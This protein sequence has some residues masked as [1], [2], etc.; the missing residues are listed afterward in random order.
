MNI[1][2]HLTRKQ[3][4]DLKKIFTKI[5]II[6]FFNPHNIEH[7]KAYRVLEKTGFWPKDFL[8]KDGEGAEWPMLWQVE[9]AAKMAQAWLQAAE[10]G[11]IIGM[12]HFDQ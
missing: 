11:H 1:K 10:A 8:P 4:K 2:K 3:N 6:D 5:S 9:L 12:P 7:L